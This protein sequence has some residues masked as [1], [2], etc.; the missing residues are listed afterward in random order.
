LCLAEDC[1]LIEAG[2]WIDKARNVFTRNIVLP[3]KLINKVVRERGNQ[4]V[5]ATAYRYNTDN[6]DESFL[7]GDMYFDFDNKDDFEPV[8]ADAITVMAYL[9]T[10]FKIESE[11]IRIYFSGNKGVHIIIPASIFGIAPDKELNGIFRTIAE[12][13]QSFTRHKTMDMRIYDN[14]RLFRIPNSIHES[15]GLYKIPITLQELRDLQHEDIKATAQNPRVMDVKSPVYNHFAHSQY[16]RYKEKH[17]EEAIKRNENITHNGTLKYMP[18]CVRHLVENGAQSGNRNNSLA[19]LTSF[20]KNTGLSLD[21]TM[22]T[23]T[24][25]NDNNVQPIKHSELRATARSVYKGKS[26]YGCTSM[27]VVSVCDFDNCK[28]MNKRR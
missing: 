5:F 25:W 13:V 9:K 3:A 12:N 8:R 2:Y 19:A 27:K 23:L 26:S 18:P 17:A 20:Y 4:G 16:V 7:Y 14:K 11:Q 28:L 10:V 24:E 15:T 1:Y 6:P 21:E 22:E